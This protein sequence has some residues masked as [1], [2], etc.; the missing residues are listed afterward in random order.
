MSNK[1]E[2]FSYCIGKKHKDGSISTY[3]YGS[4]VFF[5]ENIEEAKEML[6]WVKNRE[7]NS[8]DYK[9]FKLVEI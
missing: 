5:A 7:K 4:N 9:I 1:S 6:E 2:Y 8:D 3:T